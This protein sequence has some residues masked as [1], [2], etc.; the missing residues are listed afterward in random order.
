MLKTNIMKNIL[1]LLLSFVS[2]LSY[3]QTPFTMISSKAES[4]A[5]LSANSLNNPWVGAKLVYNVTGDV[6]NSFILSGSAMYIAA[7]GD[8][9]A[10]PV[11]ANVG[12]SPDSLDPDNGVRLGIYPWYML[13]DKK[14]ISILCHGGIDYHI[15][16]KSET[17]YLT[18]F[19]ILAGIEAAI[20]PKDRSMPTTISVGPEYTLSTGAVTGSSW[21]L[22]TTAVVPFA[23]GMGILIEGYT[24]F[25]KGGQSGLKIGV[26]VN[27]SIK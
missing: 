7:Q 19:G 5:A 13:S 10:I 17:G 21:S 27:N 15:G 20:Y 16:D 4:P 11:L 8:K 1:I 6:S 3:G 23:N 22:N 18:E 9:Y 26:I 14:D 12:L 2:L 24:P 25:T